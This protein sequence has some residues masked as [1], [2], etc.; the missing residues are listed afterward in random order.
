MVP[1]CILLAVVGS[2]LATSI[3]AQDKA[4]FE[5]IDTHTHFYDPSRPQ[6]APW[7]G[8]SD[9]LLY[10]P[11]LPG[12]Y[13]KLARPFGVVGAIVVEASPWLEDNQWLLDLAAK[14]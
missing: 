4:K 11:V 9:K 5:I 13:K 2:L 10:R 12:E 8:K 1:R 7:P 14:D 6:G 3:S